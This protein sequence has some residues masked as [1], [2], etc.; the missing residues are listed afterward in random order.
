MLIVD[1][2][3]GVVIDRGTCTY[4]FI[5]SLVHDTFS[6]SLETTHSS[7]WSGRLFSPN[8][9]FSPS[10][11]YLAHHPPPT[12]PCSLPHQQG[13]LNLNLLGALSG[14]LSSKSKKTTHTNADGSSTTLED[15]HDQGEQ[16]SLPSYCHH[17]T[18]D[19]LTLSLHSISKRSSE[20]KGERARGCVCRGGR[21]E[22]QG[23]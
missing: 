9:L 5:E 8:P 14:A 3:A 21:E 6:R 4:L 18:M 23:A 16:L 13:G 22:D 19:I 7:S 15:R 12:N 20:W 2:G 10:P 1:V 11:Q 17:H